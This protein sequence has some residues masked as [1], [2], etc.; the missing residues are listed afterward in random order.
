MACYALVRQPR[1]PLGCRVPAGG[2]SYLQPVDLLDSGAV[3]DIQ[4][5]SRCGRPQSPR[6]AAVASR[7]RL[8]LF[9]PA[10]PPRMLPL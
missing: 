3:D 8:T 9:L 5:T 2:Q 10:T 1:A 4:L 7:P 6:L